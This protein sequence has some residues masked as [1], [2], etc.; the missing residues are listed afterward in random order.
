MLVIECKGKEISNFLNFQSKQQEK[1]Y[2]SFAF[3]DHT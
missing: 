2:R 1:I 3:Y